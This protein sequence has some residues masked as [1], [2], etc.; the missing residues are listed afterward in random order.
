MS[1]IPDNRVPEFKE[2]VPQEVQSDTLDPTLF[3]EFTA[4]FSVENSLGSWAANGFSVASDFVRE[5]GYDPFELTASG[6]SDIAGY[7]PFAESFIDSVSRD[8]TASIKLQID[9]ELQDR[10]TLQAGGWSAVAAQLVASATDPLY[11]P[12]MYGGG[13]TLISG[14]SALAD[15]AKL[16]AI[17]FAGEVAAEMGKH[18][19]Q[20]TR[21]EAESMVNIA[22]ATLISGTLGVVASNLTG[23][24]YARSAIETQ[25]NLDDLRPN[26]Y[27][28]NSAGAAQVKVASFDQ[29]EPVNVFGIQGWKFSPLARTQ[30]S[31]SVGT[32]RLAS[33]M[34][35]SPTVTEGNKIGL[36]TSPEGG[37]VET[38]MKQWDAPMV[39]ALQEIEKEFK[40]Y[41]QASMPVIQAQD[42]VARFSNTNLEKKLSPAAFREEVGKA[43][44]RG[45]V[46]E[47]PEVQRAAESARKVFDRMKDEAI[48]LNLL[49]E[50]V[51]VST[52]S[53]YLTRIYNTGKITAKRDEWNRVVY[54]W[55]DG[56]RKGAQ[57]NMD[58]R[59]AKGEEPPESMVKQAELTDEELNLAVADV[60]D[61]ILGKSSGRT[62]YNVV[63][64]ERGPLKERVFNIPDELIED[65]LESDIDIVLRQYTRTMAPD[66]EISRRFGSPDMKSQIDDLNDDYMELLEEAKDEKQRMQIEKW[67]DSDVRDIEAMR[68]RLRGNYKTPADPNS[69]FTRAGRVI[70]DV[71]FL[72]MLGGMTLSA[73]P[74]LARPIAVNGLKPV[75]KALVSMVSDRDIWKMSKAEA[76]RNAIGLDMVLNSRAASLADV[77]DVY[78]TITPFERGLRRMSDGFSKIAIMSQWNAALKQFSGVVTADRILTEAVNWSRGTISNSARTRLAASGIDENMAK[79][80]AAQFRKHGESG[81]IKLSHSNMWDDPYVEQA[82]KSAVLKD[83]DR[84]ILT[85]GEGE[86]PL[87]TSSETGKM[88]FQFKTFAA[89]AHHKILIADLQYADA[90]ALNGFLIS[91]ALGSLTYAAKQTVAGREIETDPNKLVIEAL[92][93]SG[94]FGYLWDMNNTVEK[95]SR[96]E[97]GVSKLA[98]GQPMSRYASRNWAGALLGPS[99]GTVT[100]IGEVAG[101]VSQVAFNPEVDGFSKSDVHKMRKL[102]PFQNLF[103]MRQLLNELEEKVPTDD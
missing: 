13:R 15:G 28:N 83:V 86:K 89:T 94:G 11:L 50:D 42:L 77:Q 70:R 24:E 93:R 45:D 87:W 43:A 95:L 60:T 80:I 82:F 61:N 25:S 32:R 48:G 69:F 17:G 59:I 51:G 6:V 5:D 1:L 97:I 52:A 75:S 88:I 53:S 19:T 44:R 38:R 31:P 12:M 20:E 68:D 35:E 29:L 101:A 21:T 66:I 2:D 92:D 49:P 100:E 47:I 22:G 26:L 30:M 79:E 3:E 4:A 18:Q 23:K 27:V 33:D 67:R 58:E 98:G 103:Y 36:A 99:F 63:V 40:N 85:P 96:G 37:S 8:Q 78:S 10:K 90:Q 76:K 41:R 102:L 46:H 64:S 74:D 91:A 72:R 57:R 54:G 73:I 39:E 55:F 71:N 56:I 14:K 65:F 16:G 9:R 62:D 84:A 34:M 81:T 7:E